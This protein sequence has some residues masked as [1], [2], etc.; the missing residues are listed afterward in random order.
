MVGPNHDSYHGENLVE[1][2]LGGHPTCGRQQRERLGSLRRLIV[3][4]LF[5]KS[6]TELVFRRHVAAE[7]QSVKPLASQPPTGGM[8]VFSNNIKI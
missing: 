1:L 4:R 3:I 6:Q 5:I 8:G 2:V 7:W